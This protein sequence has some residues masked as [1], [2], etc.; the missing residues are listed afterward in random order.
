VINVGT[1]SHIVWKCDMCGN[2]RIWRTAWGVQPRI[3][4]NCED[5]P[6]DMEFCS[7]V[8]NGALA[9]WDERPGGRFV[10]GVDY[11]SDDDTAVTLCRRESDGTVR[12]MDVRMMKKPP[13]GCLVVSDERQGYYTRKDTHEEMLGCVGVVGAR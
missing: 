12:V 9:V 4:C 7:A 11:G 3:K 6:R 5:F 1:H 13:S 2:V 10:M 8:P